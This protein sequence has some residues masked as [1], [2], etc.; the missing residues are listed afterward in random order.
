MTASNTSDSIYLV[1]GSLPTY[2]LLV[3]FLAGVA[4]CQR[5]FPPERIFIA[6]RG[7]VVG[8]LFVPWQDVQ[9]RR[10]SEEDQL[11]LEPL[12]LRVFGYDCTLNPSPNNAA[13]VNEF[14]LARAQRSVGSQGKG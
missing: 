4:I 10:S 3:G 12:D 2:G 5:R 6:E 1:S 13:A 8:S 11:G 7:V 14:V 9:F